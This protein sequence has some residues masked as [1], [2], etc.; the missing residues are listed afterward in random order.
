MSASDNTIVSEDIALRVGLAARTLPDTEP[1]R[2]L[3]VLADAIGLPPS[4]AKLKTL[5]VKQI[6]TACDGILADLPGPKLKEAVAILRGET[7][8]EVSDESLPKPEA[9]KDGDMPGSVRIA[10][11]SNSGDALDGHFGSCARFLVY[12]VSPT[13]SRLIDVRTPPRA[14]ADLDK[15]DQRA[16]LIK[17]CQI[18]YVVSVGGP[19]AAKLVR[20]KVHPIKMPDGGPAS[21]IIHRLS[22][23]IATQP[24]PWLA[25]I[26]GLASED[27]FHFDLAE[28]A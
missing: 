19:A 4:P 13:E 16:D 18:A 10:L 22:Q 24:P 12:Q 7:D 23:T 11:A 17:D 26:M 25:K 9:Y 14:L 20:R 27:R 8:I 2:L 21:Q 1:R 3:A 5:T 28:D 6:R 15:N